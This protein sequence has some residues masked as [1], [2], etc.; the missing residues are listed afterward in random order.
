MMRRTKTKSTSV[1][2]DSLAVLLDE[3]SGREY[4]VSMV[5]RFR[6]R[7][8]DYAVMYRYE[9]DD[10]THRDPEIVIMRAWRESDGRR[11]FTSIRNKRELE[12]VFQLF[13]NRFHEALS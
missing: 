1:P 4:Y 12:L 10:G 7:E 2:D 3:K 6:Y 5:D 8:H 13:Y 9:P 11:V